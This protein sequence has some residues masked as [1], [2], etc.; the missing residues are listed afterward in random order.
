MLAALLGLSFLVAVSAQDSATPTGCQ[1]CARTVGSAAA[2]G[3][4]RAALLVP[5][6]VETLARGRIENLLPI[7]ILT[8]LVCGACAAGI[9]GSSS[10]GE[11]GAE[12]NFRG[13]MAPAVLFETYYDRI[14]RYAFGGA[15][16]G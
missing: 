2:P 8:V 5:P 4:K 6:D 1:T 9:R 7:G 16:P 3:G 14:Y 11:T 12:M 15:A 13:F 10:I